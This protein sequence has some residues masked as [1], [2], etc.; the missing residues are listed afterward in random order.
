MDFDLFLLVCNYIGTIA[1]A[2]SGAI[3][4]FDKH[5]DIF[6]ISLLA[7]VTAVGGGILRD[8]IISRFPSALF[9]PSS[10]YLAI[11]VAIIMY[12]FIVLNRS[13]YGYNSEIYR[14]LREA[15]LIFDSIGLII[16][17]L[18]GPTVLIETKL[19]LIS[20]GLL[21]CLTGAGGGIIRDLLINEVPSVLKEDIYALLS[22]AVGISYYG[23]T[24]FIGFSRISTFI[25]IFIL[26]FIIRMII[27]R[28]RLSLPNMENR[29]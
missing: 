12:I 7:I 21:A 18:I 19:N 22:F 1:F 6:G 25:I 28:F 14:W 24:H 26:G 15:Y 17:S 11:F 2:A 23:L 29:G 3:K 13:N 16:F 20:A 8:S 10:I 5:L 9:D 27:I 4:G